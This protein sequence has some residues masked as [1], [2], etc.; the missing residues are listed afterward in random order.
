MPVSW[1]TRFFSESATSTLRRIVERTRCPGTEV[2]RSAAS[3]SASRRSCGMSFRAQTYR[4]AAASSTACWRSVS[5][6]CGTSGPPSEDNAFEQAVPHHPVAAVRAA[7]DLAAGV[8]A[9]QRRLGVGV[10]DEPAVLVV[11]VGVGE[12]LLAQR[13]DAARAIAGKHVRERELG[14]VLR[15]P[16]GVEPDRRAAV[17]GLDSS[18]LLDLAEDRLA[19]DVARRERVAE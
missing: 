13:I 16:R 17:G 10:V 4:C 18:A 19:D 14:I 5:S 2:S 12:D 15:D 7:R 3:A 6:G 11:E 8:H 9:L 1:Q